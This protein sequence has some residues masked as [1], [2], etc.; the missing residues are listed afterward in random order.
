MKRAAAIAICMIVASALIVIGIVLLLY[1]YSASYGNNAFSDSIITKK[2]PA[3]MGDV[4]FEHS[5]FP[6]GSRWLPSHATAE[7]PT[8]LKPEANIDV[9][10][11]EQVGIRLD[12]SSSVAEENRQIFLYVQLPPPLEYQA[13]HEVLLYSSSS[14]NNSTSRRRRNVVNEVTGIGIRFGESNDIR[15][16][17]L[18]LAREPMSGIALVSHLPSGSN[19]YQIRI[20]I[21]RHLCQL[22][23]DQTGSNNATCHS[24]VWTAYS[25]VDFGRAAVEQ[26][27]PRRLYLA[28][29]SQCSAARTPCSVDSCRQCDGS[30]I[31][32]A[33]NPATRRYKVPQMVQSIQ[34]AYDTYRVRDRV[35][36]VR[37]DN[38][39]ILFD[40]GCMAE[41]ARLNIGPVSAVAGVELRVD[42]EPDCTADASSSGWH[43]ALTCYHLS[44][45]NSKSRNDGRDIR[46][47]SKQSEFSVS[48]LSSSRSYNFI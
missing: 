48:S 4:L 26:K 45:F 13:K 5:E 7:A 36:V 43:F 33:N 11:L 16:V 46:L 14:S 2:K 12:S 38:G 39:D 32:G 21:P 29:G 6:P 22:L 10:A 35:R 44:D 25:I 34:L 15:I 9:A 17:P 8:A 28:C 47:P 37:A 19:I 24:F 3:S 23:W 18:E 27:Q 1:L 40:S 41:K 20:T 30:Q 42:V 31:G